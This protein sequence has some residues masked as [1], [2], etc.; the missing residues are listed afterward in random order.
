MREE[1]SFGYTWLLEFPLG[2][3]ENEDREKESEGKRS[4]NCKNLYENLFPKNLNDTNSEP[5]Y[6]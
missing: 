3:W 5:P 6:L 4:E 2:G 1:S